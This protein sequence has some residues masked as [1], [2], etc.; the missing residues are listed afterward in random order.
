MYRSWA[1]VYLAMFFLLS[2]ALLSYAKAAAI[3]I[4]GTDSVE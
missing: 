2:W 4:V 3:S 1:S